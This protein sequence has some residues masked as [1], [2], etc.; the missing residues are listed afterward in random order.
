MRTTLTLDDDVAEKLRQLTRTSG[1]TFKALVNETLR[2]GLN[3]PRD[4]GEP[5]PFKVEARPLKARPGI[6][7]DNIAEVLEQL[8]GAGNK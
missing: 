4:L 8:D 1:R 2:L 7:L 6:D 5:E 3:A